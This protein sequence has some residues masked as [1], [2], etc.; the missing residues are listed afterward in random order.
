MQSLYP[1][2]RAMYR[3]VPEALWKMIRYEGVSRPIR[4]VTVMIAGAGPAHALY[5]SCYELMKRVL[6]GTET[7]AKNPIA[8]GN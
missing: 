7:G 6:S 3:T 4:G 5:F 2:P 8:Q 1:N